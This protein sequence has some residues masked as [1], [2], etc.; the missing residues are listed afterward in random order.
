MMQGL[1]L[2]ALFS[3]WQP[4]V[5]YYR[6]A[7]KYFLVAV[8]HPEL[9]PAVVA[10]LQNSDS[11]IAENIAVLTC[12]FVACQ[13]WWLFQLMSHSSTPILPETPFVSCGRNVTFHGLRFLLW[14]GKG[15]RCTNINNK[16]NLPLNFLDDWQ[17]Q[18][19]HLLAQEEAHHRELPDDVEVLVKRPPRWMRWLRWLPRVLLL[20]CSISLLQ[21]LQLFAQGIS[22]LG[23]LLKI[24][25]QLSVF[26]VNLVT[27]A[28]MVSRSQS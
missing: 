9:A 6:R 1:T 16:N 5:T 7:C 14:R 13:Q 8:L 17:N 26:F 21:V 27:F 11:N 28:R 20:E 23:C 3:G 18:I 25:T 2:F 24:R 15:T 22:G 10:A 19:N 4:V 12:E